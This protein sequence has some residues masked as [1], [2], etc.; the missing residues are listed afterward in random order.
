MKSAFFKDIWRTIGNTKKRFICIALIVTLGVTMMCGL[1]AGCIDLRYSADRFFDEQNLFDIRIL[2]THGIT[3]DDV[4]A[5]D[6]L[7]IIEAAE[8]GFSETV[9][10]EEDSMRRSIEVRTLSE[11]KLNQPY[12]LEG[13]LPENEDE[14]AIT[15]NYANQTDKGLGDRICLKEE[16]EYLLEQE[17]IITG[18]IVD[19]M[20]VNSS[21]G[22]MG[23]RSTA[24][25]DY[26]GYVTPEAVDSDI[27]TVLYLTVDGARELNSYTDE[28][29][30]KINTVVDII[31]GEIKAQREK[32]RYDE[33]YG[34]AMEEWQEGEQ[35]MKE[36]FAKAD[37]EIADA[38]AEIADG[39]RELANARKEIAS[40]KQELID[41]EA[42]LNRQEALAEQEFANA[43]NEIASGYAQI[44]AGRQE[45]SA[46][47]EQLAAGQAELDDGA[48]QLKSMESLLLEP[49]ESAYATLEAQEAENYVVY[50]EKQQLVESIEQQIEQLKQQM[51]DPEVEADVKLQL[52]AELAGCQ[53]RH[54][55][56]QLELSAAETEKSLLA[57]RR[58]TLDKEKAGVEALFAD[59]WKQIEDGQ[60]ELN[61]GWDQYYAGVGELEAA[62]AQ[63]NAG[64]VELEKQEKNAKEQIEAGRQEIISG[65]KKLKD[66][67]AQLA[68]GAEELAEGESV[69]ATNL[70]EYEDEKAKAEKE[71]ADAK[72][73]IEEIDVTKWY[74]Q[75]RFSLSGCN[76]VK[77][78]AASIQ[79]LGDLFP[80]LFLI[81]SILISL[82]TITR[83]VEEERGLIGTYKALGFSNGQIRKK[84]MIY[85][86]A[87][88][89][90]GGTLGDIGGYVIIPSIL[91]VVFHVMYSIPTYFIQ[92]DLLYGLGG[93][94][95]F[96]LGIL[97]ATAVAC[98]NALKKTPAHL[99]RPK[100]PK[101]GTRV[102]L[103]RIPFIWKR[104]SFLNKVTARNL[105]RY[106]KRLLMTVFGITGCTALLLCGFTIKDTVSELMP[107]QYHEIYRYDLMTVATEDEFEALIEV[108]E[109][110]QEIQDYIPVKIESVEISND[111]G[112]KE[113]VQL[114]VT[115]EG[116][117]LEDYICMKDEDGQIYRLQDDEVYV[118]RNVMRIL[119][120]QEGDLITLQNLD[121]EEADAE[122]TRIVENYFG[123]S[124]Y[125]TEKTYLELFEGFECNGTLARL[126]KEC[127]DH[128]VYADEIS[129]QKG[130]L[131][132][133]STQQM[134]A[135]FDTSFV[136]INMVVY[137]ILVLAA[138]LAFVVLFTLSNTNISERERELATIKVLGFFNKEVH[139][140]V[141]KETIILTLI[142]IL[143]GM[144]T[145]SFL[146]NVL[147]SSLKFSS[148]EFYEILYPVS[149]LYAGGITIV[150]AFLVNMIT[151]RIL[152]KINMVEALKSVE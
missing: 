73:K 3:E 80:I 112:K 151:D 40:G 35:K 98:Q 37:A 145:G 65:R 76:N 2:S 114:I 50:T 139:L 131:S 45:L 41:G 6:S 138:M 70:S 71:L 120:Y 91:F 104:M 55:Q 130:V 23:F 108:F 87:A 32:V 5:L 13:R 72:E 89:L 49:I 51:Q 64:L 19:S 105:F 61:A 100:A 78:D 140:Y 135:E 99:M 15:A 27:Y 147:M 117:S 16:A 43:R 85:A 63:L 123:N 56:A 81:V 146:G 39:K 79:A 69:L 136:L 36:E 92:V 7:E 121:L 44:E 82:T 67:E 84:Y 113:T 95:L 58:E 141:N 144:P 52:A 127:E 31:E 107:Q 152:D 68:D 12:L 106:K 125:M 28:Y 124:V 74:V 47:Y 66:A 21:E 14:I 48:A 96:A 118:T 103:E 119:G 102:L 142:G 53:A 38:Q 17:Y 83:M 137:L 101:A 54:A 109:S 111:E 93:I 22:S 94:L 42:E 10:I 75:D 1:R 34:D 133:I 33:I 57:S 134:E 128:A 46:A 129:R 8:G 18:I 59:S 132:S 9:Y 97:V 4:K 11:K 25:T 90:I 30:K 86:A 77:S 122:V 150:F 115:P 126:T 29:E 110:G 143:C 88:T 116:E 149:Y 62:E 24:T 148:L 20:D 60:A 26:V